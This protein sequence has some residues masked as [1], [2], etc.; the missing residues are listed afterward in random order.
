MSISKAT[1]ADIPALVKLVNSAYR[2]EASTKGWTTEAHLLKG[3]LRT[4]EATVLQQFNNFNSVILKFTSN[5]SDIM[6]CVYLDQQEDKLYLGMLS[7][8]PTA[9]SQGIGK[10][11]LAAA[12]QFAKEQ[13]CAFIYMTVISVRHELIEWYKRNGYSITGEK[14]PFPT[15]ER[16]GIPT[17]PLE[18]IVLKKSISQ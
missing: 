7:V 6:G 17:Q 4:D 5:G 3:E 18:F 9:Q 10:K 12:E 2:G 8:S 1:T 13:Q 16:F 11:L 14:K 15:D